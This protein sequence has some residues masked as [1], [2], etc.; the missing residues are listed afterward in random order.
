MSIYPEFWGAAL[1]PAPGSRDVPSLGACRT[2]ARCS[3]S[4]PGAEGN[5]PGFEGAGSAPG[6][7]AAS[8]GRR[9]GG[10]HFT[11]S[12]QVC[13]SPPVR[14]PT[15]PC[16]PE[17]TVRAGGGWTRACLWDI[18]PHPWLFLWL[19]AACVFCPVGAGRLDLR[20]ALLYVAFLA[21]NPHIGG[22]VEAGRRERAGDPASA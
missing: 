14:A 12:W 21:Q 22:A 19:P 7:L 5:F 16:H 20:P 18:E 8:G 4:I 15:P 11:G 17:D 9:R 6:T 13:V 1:L 2:P 3:F 10:S